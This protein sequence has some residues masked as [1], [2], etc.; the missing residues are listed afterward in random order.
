MVDLHLRDIYS[1]ICLPLSSVQIL[2]QGASSSGSELCSSANYSQLFG[3]AHRL[4]GSEPSRYTTHDRRAHSVEV[5]TL[6]TQVNVTLW[7]P[8]NQC[9]HLTLTPFNQYRRSW[10]WTRWHASSWPVYG[11]Q[12][13]TRLFKRRE[14]NITISI[15]ESGLRQCLT[16]WEV[17]VFDG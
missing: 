15:R 5:S 8:F 11:A 14:T 12:W 7:Y 16:R 4:V 9:R 2:V 1:Y 10:K 6:E 17:G 3:S 13:R